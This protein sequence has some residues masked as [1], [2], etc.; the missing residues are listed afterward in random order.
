MLKCA[1][2]SHLSQSDRD[3]FK[4]LI[5]KCDDRVKFRSALS[6]DKFNPF[7]SHVVNMPILSRSPQ[8]CEV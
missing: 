3:A 4:I 7:P 8:V 6:A 2:G 1:N 5:R